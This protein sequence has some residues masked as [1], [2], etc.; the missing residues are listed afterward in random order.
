MAFK[1]KDNII[2]KSDNIIHSQYTVQIKRGLNLLAKN[3]I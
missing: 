3:K 1:H 2:Q